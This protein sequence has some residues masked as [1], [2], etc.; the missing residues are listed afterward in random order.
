M[1]AIRTLAEIVYVYA[2]AIFDLFCWWMESD[3]DTD[4]AAS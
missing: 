3:D 4:D 2:T 1:S